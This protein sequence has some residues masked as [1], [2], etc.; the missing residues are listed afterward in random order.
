MHSNH[1]NRKSWLTGIV[2]SLPIWVG[3][4]VIVLSFVLW[5]AQKKSDKAEV[6]ALVSV[7]SQ[8]VQRMLETVVHHQ[9]A[10]VDEQEL[11]DLFSGEHYS[12][13]SMR[14]YKNSVLI[15]AKGA[16]DQSSLNEWGVIRNINING[17][18]WKIDLWPDNQLLKV[19]KTSLSDLA[20]FMGLIVAS[21][22]IIVGLLAMLATQRERAVQEVNRQ[23]RFE[24]REKEKLQKVLLQSQKLQ[25]VGTLAG[26]I[27]HDFNNILYAMMGYVAMA[28]EDVEKDGLLYRNL[29]KVL[30]AGKRGQKLVSS[31][32]SF[33]R[34]QQAQDVQK[35]DLADMLSHVFEL[36]YPTIPASISLVKDINIDKAYILGDAHALEQVMVNMINNAVDAMDGRGVLSISLTKARFREAYCIAIQDTGTGMT[37]ETKQRLFDPFYTT[38]SVDKGTGLGLSI[39]HGI[40]R[41]HKGSIHIDTELGRGSTFSIYLPIAQST[42]GEEEHG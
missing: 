26:G 28:K 2:T 14:L 3:L 38:K 32:L 1:L 39:A 5:S 35:I 7:Q 29:G 31:I 41:D 33:S 18:R 4:V 9:A 37:E 30:E 10:E 20:L 40:I 24:T 27:A 13:V 8:H 11:H 36:M 16:E 23:L 12:G 34:Q 21:L 22:L 42:E 15:Y 17:D 6:G 19:Y 25:A